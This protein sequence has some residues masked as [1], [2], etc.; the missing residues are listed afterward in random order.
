MA[1]ESKL[2]ELNESLVRKLSSAK[3]DPEWLLSLRLDALKQFNLLPMP[4]QTYGLH[5]IS[6]VNI[7]ISEL[8]PFED[9]TKNKAFANKEVIVEDLSAAASNYENLLKPLLAR[10]MQNKLEALH[11]AFW[12]N[13][14]FV[15]AKGKGKVHIQMRQKQ[16]EIVWTIVVAEEGSE[17]EIL[18]SLASFNDE[19][20]NRLEFIDVIARPGSKVRFVSLQKLSK[21]SQSTISR[22]ASIWNGATVE[23]LDMSLGGGSSKQDVISLLNGEGASTSIIGA[24]FADGD[25]QLDMMAKAV[26]NSRNTTSNMKIKGALDGRSKAIVQGFTRIEAKAANSEGHQKENIL[27]LSDQAKASPIPKLEIDNYDVKASHEASVGQLDAEKL[28]YMM[29]RGM[30]REEAERLV[31]EGFFDP[32]IRQIGIEQLELELRQAI[33]AR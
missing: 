23:W 30:E 10:G 8:K 15:H 11:N 33:S 4:Q 5:V 12:N 6:P 7:T 14:V 17:V 20:A 32:L 31:V 1:G 24:F 19:K 28:F 18:E 16:T 2:S 9:I 3:G 21:S 26:H 29:S 22:K 27:L 25:Q 13:G